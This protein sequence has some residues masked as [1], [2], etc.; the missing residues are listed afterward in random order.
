MSSWSGMGFCEG[1]KE[2]RERERKDEGAL[3][4]LELKLQKRKYMYISANPVM[5][6]IFNKVSEVI[7]NR[8]EH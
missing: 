6:D 1:K 8:I 4:K 3:K 7:Q 2:K 5:T